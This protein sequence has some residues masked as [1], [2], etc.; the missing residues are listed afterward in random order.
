MYFRMAAGWTTTVPFEFIRMP[1]ANYFYGGIDLPEAGDQL[2]AYIA[3]FGVQAVI[4]DPIEANFE[5]FKP[6]FDSLGIAGL[7]EKGVR[8]YKIP[9][10]SFSAYAQLPA[11]HI[12]AP[13]SAPPLD[14]ILQ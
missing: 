5:S 11:A 3:R 2:K 14:A 6:T 13:A 4:A 12:R 7:D 1:V 9:R 8:I 10:H